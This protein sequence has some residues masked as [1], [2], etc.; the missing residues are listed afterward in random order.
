M[1]SLFLSFFPEKRARSVENRRL[2]ESPMRSARSAA[3]CK[4]GETR[5]VEKRTRRFNPRRRKRMYPS[6]PSLPL[7]LSLS[8]TLSLSLSPVFERADPV[9]S[10]DA[11]VDCTRAR[12]RFFFFARISFSLLLCLLR[13]RLLLPCAVSRDSPFPPRGASFSAERQRRARAQ[14]APLSKL[15]TPVGFG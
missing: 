6:L 2:V 5:A 13:R 7:P 15:K 14:A 4:L 11:R 10:G 12:A 8:L 3:F 9:D 1:L